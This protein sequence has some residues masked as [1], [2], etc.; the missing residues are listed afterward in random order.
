MLVTIFSMART[1]KDLSKEQGGAGGGRGKCG[2]FATIIRCGGCVT[3]LSAPPPL[4]GM[5]IQQHLM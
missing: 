5:W 4:S 1:N 2:M 3:L